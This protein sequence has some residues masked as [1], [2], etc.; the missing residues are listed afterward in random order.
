MPRS[1]Y[2]AVRMVFVLPTGSLRMRM[3]WG[4]LDVGE[5]VVVDY[6]ENLHLVERGHALR[7]LVVVHEHDLLPARAQQVEAAYRAH[8]LVGGVE[9]GVGAVAALEHNLAHV[10]EVVG[11]VEG[12]DVLLLDYPLD[13]QGLVYYARDAAGGER[14]RDEA[15]VLR[16]VLP[17]AAYVRAADD[18]AAHSGV[19]GA[20]DYVRLVAAD[21]YRVRARER[22]V[23][24][25]LRQGYV[26]LAAERPWPCS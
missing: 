13:G 6:L 11:E 20:A 9:H 21:E 2:I 24:E 23:V 12:D 16:R 8:D 1:W 15:D 10:V 19:D 5:A 17:L 7:G 4:R 14:R 18:E 22:R 3:G 25:I 26:E